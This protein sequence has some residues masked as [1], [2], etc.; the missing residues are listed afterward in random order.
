MNPSSYIPIYISSALEL[1]LN[2]DSF[3]ESVTHN[4]VYARK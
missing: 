3:Y 4:L 2:N 1:T